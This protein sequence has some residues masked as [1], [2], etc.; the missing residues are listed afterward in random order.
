MHKNNFDFIRFILSFTVILAHIIDLSQHSSLTF[1][2]PFFDSNIAVT[3][4]FIISGFLITKSY[5]STDNIKQYFIKRANR[6]LPG[7][8]FTVFCGA[9][10]LL[11]ISTLSFHEYFLSSDFY[12]YLF[13]NIIFLNFLHPCLPGVFLNNHE[14]AVNGALW[15]IKVEVGF[16]VIIPPLIYVI[17]KFSKKLFLFVFIYIAALAYK[18]AVGQYYQQTGNAIFVILAHQLPAFMSYFATGMAMHYY[19]PK[20]IN[21]KNYLI[22]IAL[23]V[24]ILEY[25]FSLE[26]LKPLA[27]TIIIFYI[28]YGFSFLN[29]FG[30]YGDFSYGIYIYHFPLI[31]LCIT[32]GFFARYNPF[33]VAV[34]III[35]V[36]I[37]AVLSWYLIEKR[38]I[39]RKFKKV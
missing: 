6:L 10:F 12:K 8:L 29:N 37:M 27:L 34:C 32:L 30:K 20:F 14:C 38:F 4:F 26:I 3:G 36:L 35:I 9:I 15:T 25:Y 2:R 28:A 21:Y 17:S 33:L 1:L 7:Y 18:Y 5:I 16:Y 19:L 31:Q 13:C 23:P 39:L 22:L 24:F 11:F